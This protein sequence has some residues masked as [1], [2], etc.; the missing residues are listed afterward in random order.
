MTK[1]TRAKWEERIREWRASGL[2]AEEFAAGKDYEPASLRWS[3]SQLRPER[4]SGASTGS[5]SGPKESRR[6]RHAESSPALPSEAPRFLPVRLRRH[7]DQAL[8]EMIVEV[9]DARI[10]VSRGVDIA[11]LGDVVRALQGVGR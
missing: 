7:P 3:A 2:S 5:L 10:R 9:G 1:H 8:A 4:Q 6:R 11:L